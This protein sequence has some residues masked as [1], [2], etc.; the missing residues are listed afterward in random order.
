MDSDIETGEQIYIQFIE[1][2]FEIGISLIIEAISRN[3]HVNIH[4]HLCIGS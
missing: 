4:L 3:T 1:S 2:C